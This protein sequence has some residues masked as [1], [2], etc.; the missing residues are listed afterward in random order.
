[1]A[2]TAG[3]DAAAGP[4]RTCVGCRSRAAQTELLRVAFVRGRITPDPRRRLPG[5]GAYL[6]PRAACLASA[7]AG[8]SRAFRTRVAAEALTSLAA[9]LQ[10]ET[11]PESAL[12]PGARPIGRCIEDEYRS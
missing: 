12:D 2:H 11:G 7:S 10:N 3:R 4:V 5:R 9:A 6:H 8:L 1:M